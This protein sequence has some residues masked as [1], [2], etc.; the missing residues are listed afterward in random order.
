[1]KSVRHILI[2]N[3]DLEMQIG[4]YG[5]E[6]GRT[7]R[8]R[9]N[10]DLSV[11][12]TP[13]EDDRLGSV[14]DYVAVVD[15]IRKAALSGHVNLVETLAERIADIC[16]EDSRVLKARIRVEKPDAIPEAES[17]GVEIER[18]RDRT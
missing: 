11:E 5:H 17:A 18:T 16:L 14:V 2:Q 3:L 8:A 9:I 12:D 15:R 10:L 13:A 1:M 6:K 4:F 7:Q